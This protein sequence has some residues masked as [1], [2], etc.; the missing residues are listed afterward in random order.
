[1]VNRLMRKPI[2]RPKQEQTVRVRNL[3]GIQQGWGIYILPADPDEWTPVPKSLAKVL[4]GQPENYELWSTRPQNAYHR[5]RIHPNQVLW[6]KRPIKKW[7]SV[8]IVIPVFN[9]PDLLSKC[10]DSLKL[11]KYKGGIG[12]TLV[13]NASTDAD[14]LRIVRAHPKLSTIRFDQPRGFSTAVNAGMK[15]WKADFYV[16]FNQDCEI[17]DPD[18]L[19]NMI[20]W[21]LKRPQCGIAGPKLV[22]P[23]KKG[24]SPRIQHIGVIFPQ[25]STGSHRYAGADA[26]IPQ[27][28]LFER[29]P[30]VTGAVFLIRAS[31]LPQTGYFDER[32]TFC[33]ED[34]EFCLRVSALFGHEI[35]Y[36]PT[37]TVIH[38]DHGVQKGNAAKHSAR[39]A[40]W[41]T[42]SNKF[43]RARWGSFIDRCATQSVA[44]VAD[45]FDQATG[46]LVRLIANRFV[47]SGV[48][49]MVYTAAT[50][51]KAVGEPKLFNIR[52]I[53]Q[54][55]DAEIIIAVGSGALRHTMPVRAAKKYLIACDEVPLDHE[56][57][58]TSGSQDAIAARFAKRVL[59][60]PE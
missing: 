17:I 56:L 47:V 13:D 16:L 38:H 24:E 10:L 32:M 34:T 3:T 18:W 6:P 45:Q 59:G 12:I 8:R 23:F 55:E 7:P 15:Q 48:K 2:H 26:S 30:A 21:M 35:W 40:E 43:M 33:C 27:A 14:T 5:G 49:T 58:E 52:H 29:V 19:T 1:M 42:Q 31:I 28:G 57:V 50:D 54:F 25:G 36:V 53:S 37:A 60:A 22:Y 46:A 44:F 9:S 39:I 11:T 20:R 41:T 51:T 4:A